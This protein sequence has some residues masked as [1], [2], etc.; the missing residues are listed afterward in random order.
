MKQYFDIV[1]TYAKT[2]HYYKTNGSKHYTIGL[3]WDECTLKI[4]ESVF[5]RLGISLIYINILCFLVKCYTFF[6]WFHPTQFFRFAEYLRNIRKHS[7]NICPLTFKY[8]LSSSIIALIF[9]TFQSI[10]ISLRFVQRFIYL[11]ILY[12]SQSC[13]TKPLL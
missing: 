13:R 12:S 4:C 2:F 6:N 10:S 8:F 1:N 11:N 7:L 3:R 5:K 9:H